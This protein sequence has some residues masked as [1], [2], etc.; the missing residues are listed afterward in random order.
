MCTTVAKNGDGLIFG[1]NMDI[2]EG[3]GERLILV[4][5]AYPISYKMCKGSNHHF[6]FMGIGTVIDGY[7]LFA[8]AVNEFGLCVA[9]LN[10][11]GNACYWRENR[12]K[13]NIAPYELIPWLLSTCKTISDAISKLKR[14]NIISV[15]FK[16]DV[17][18]PQ[19]H[20]HIADKRGSIVYESIREGSRIYKNPA[21]VVTN[22][23]GFDTQ[24]ALISNY[25][26]LSNRMGSDGLSFVKPYSLG[27]GAYGLPGDYSSTSRFAR[28][29]FV[30]RFSKWEKGN[31]LFQMMRILDSVAV[32]KGCVLTEEGMEHYTL[33]QSVIDARECVYYFRPY[34]SMDTSRI[35]MFS[36]DTDGDILTEIDIH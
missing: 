2:E 8:E 34:G 12:S 11:V 22:N 7:P 14:V 10:F 32:P 35:E 33:Y 1:R 27:L 5:R 16:R 19:L 20:F 3:F 26:A 23:P 31:E 25:G 17:P 13:D 6:A 24:L 29:V 9:G 21:G 4:P 15:P 28:A 18:L 36:M 30:K